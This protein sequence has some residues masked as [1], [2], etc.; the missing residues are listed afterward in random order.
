MRRL[1]RRYPLQR[2]VHVSMMGSHM[3]EY[4]TYNKIRA[5][6]DVLTG[7]YLVQTQL[8]RHEIIGRFVTDAPAHVYYLQHDVMTSIDSISTY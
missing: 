5:D 4:R 2:Q 7:L 8:G 1:L 3:Y 6:G